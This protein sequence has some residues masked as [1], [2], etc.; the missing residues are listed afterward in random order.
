MPI[1][2][3]NEGPAIATDGHAVLDCRRV[4]GNLPYRVAILG[5]Q[6]SGKRSGLAIAGH[7]QSIAGHD[8]ASQPAEILALPDEFACHFGWLHG[9][10]FP[11]LPSLLRDE[12]TVILLE[13]PTILKNLLLSREYMIFV[14]CPFVYGAPVQ[15]SLSNQIS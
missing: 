7:E 1:F 2:Q 8:D 11:Q 12:F 3:G 5:P 6:R 15:I 10:V 9:E 4:Q 14:G 13:G